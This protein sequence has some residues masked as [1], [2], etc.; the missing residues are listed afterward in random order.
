MAE[1]VAALVVRLEARV[2]QYERN[3]K[4]AQ[5]QTQT[6]MNA[7]SRR[8]RG[9]SSDFKVLQ[10][11]AKR[12]AA[13]FTAYKIIQY[14]DSFKTLQNAIL[15]VS[16]EGVNLNEVTDELYRLAQRSRTSLAVTAKVYSDVKLATDELNLSQA[17]LV[18][19]VET[20]QKAA[21]G[22]AGALRQLGQGLASGTLRGDELNSVLEGAP[23]IA[24]AIAKEMGVSIGLIRQYAEEGKITTDVVVAAMKKLGPE[25]DE[26]INK[27]KITVT[28]A[29][30]ALDNAFTI[31]VGGQDSA[32]GATDALAAGLIA[33]SQNLDTV[34][35]AFVVLGTVIAGKYLSA[36]LTPALVGTAN[37][38]RGVDS[39]GAAASRS[40]TAM[41]GLKAGM[42]FFGGPIGLAITA[43]TLGVLAFS[44]GTEDA[45]DAHDRLRKAV[46]D[47][48]QRMEEIDGVE[49]RLLKSKRDLIQ[50]EADYQKAL[51]ESGEEAQDAARL[52]V[53]AIRQVIEADEARRAEAVRNLRA[54]LADAKKARQDLLDGAVQIVDNSGAA[55]GV[56]ASANEQ[57]R[58]QYLQYVRDNP[59]AS[60]EDRTKEANRLRDQGQASAGL[61]SDLRKAFVDEIDARLDAGKTLTEEQK[62]FQEYGKSIRDT[63]DTISDLEETI[64]RYTEPSELP[65]FT[66]A[67]RREREAN[68][69]TADDGY[70]EL[71][72]V[73]EKVAKKRQQ[74]AEQIAD[75]ER[76]V[77]RLKAQGALLAEALGGYESER[78]KLASD[79][80]KVEEQKLKVQHAGEDAERRAL[81][82]GATVEQAAALKRLAEERI[83][84]QQKYAAGVDLLSDKEQKAFDKKEAAAD[85]LEKSDKEQ[86]ARRERLE[87]FLEDAHKAAT[88]RAEDAAA[89]KADLDD[90]QSQIDV[91][92][93]RTAAVIAGAE[94][95]ANLEKEIKASEI[96]QRLKN[97]AVERGVA[98]TEELTQ[99]IDAQAAALVEAEAKE[100]TARDNKRKAAEAA[101]KADADAERAAKK[102]KSD[103]DKVAKKAADELKKRQEDA[104]DFAA[105]LEELQRAT[106]LEKQRTL[107]VQLGVEAEADFEAG[108]RASEIATRLKAEA[109]DKEIELTDELIAK[110]E[111]LSNAFI[112]QEEATKRAQ[113]TREEA[114]K[115]AKEEAEEAQDAA[116]RWNEAN[117]DVLNS[118]FDLLNSID[119]LD[120]GLKKLAVSMLKIIATGFLDQLNGTRKQGSGGI[121]GGIGS[122]LADVVG[123]LFARANGGPVARN[124]PYLVGENGPELMVPNQS[125]VIVPKAPRAPSGGGGGGDNIT[126]LFQFDAGVTEDGV[127]RVAQ[128]FAQRAKQEAIEEVP[129]RIKRSV[130][131]RAR[132]QG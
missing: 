46:G 40:A 121:L 19:L 128:Q 20:M 23:R 130:G 118:T 93:R 124:Q 59:N 111:R 131:Y 62:K 108:A 120:E 109:L 33:L 1:E 56:R 88:E 89:F 32:L 15:S 29:L 117:K 8:V 65:G 112:D 66:P 94:A 74:A 64:K 78:S 7:I 110:I 37:M 76:E 102:A 106:D 96:A 24:R 50:A 47:A 27:Q 43:I 97:E 92:E 49:D 11:N 82:K 3:V 119:D 31:F 72:P 14:A 114:L 83:E 115:K 9:T 129:D 116:E 60:F 77:N 86:Q 61:Y 71:P 84:L 4:R 17:E 21:P 67:E 39:L 80:L 91:A 38:V 101:R 127:R 107:A 100:A 25:I 122:G 45:A 22:A 34:A 87:E 13:G 70:S 55:D 41:R 18:R 113:E 75:A 73:D 28:Q 53:D 123:G 35:D 52:Q 90:I 51:K 10:D 95:E 99:R 68:T 81:A 58:R 104:A 54:D 69:G 105:E 2:A 132:I 26:V 6:S 126:Q 44:D 30:T 12:L 42:A 5:R 36:A 85:A 16:E 103:A 79:T 125:G 57:S 98:L 63:A 48:T